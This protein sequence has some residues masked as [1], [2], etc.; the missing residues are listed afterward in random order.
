MAFLKHLELFAWR[1]V[2]NTCPGAR[3]ELRGA[4]PKPTRTTFECAR[5]MPIPR[6]RPRFR[7][8]ILPTQINQFGP[9]HGNNING[10]LVVDNSARSRIRLD[11]AS[12]TALQGAGYRTP[13]LVYS[14][15]VSDNIV[16]SNR[17]AGFRP[18]PGHGLW[19]QRRYNR[20]GQGR[21]LSNPT[22]WPATI[23]SERPERHHDLLALRVRP[24]CRVI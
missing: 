13:E 24:M 21:G 17:T 19:E 2:Q 18:R 10:K 11:S 9:T 15:V 5:S 4:L 16:I 7:V 1:R 6:S 22:S 3:D 23:S 20:R 14:S 8:W 12:A